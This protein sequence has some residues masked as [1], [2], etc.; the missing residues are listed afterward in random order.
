MRYFAELG[1]A[2]PAYYVKVL[3]DTPIHSVSEMLKCSPKNL[4]F[5]GISLIMI[6][7]LLRK[8]PLARALKRSDPPVASENLT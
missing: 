8:S 4:V 7:S 1:I 6:F 2:L 5:S 3:E